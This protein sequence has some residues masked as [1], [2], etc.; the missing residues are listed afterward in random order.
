VKRFFS[1][2]GAGWVALLVALAIGAVLLAAQ[3]VR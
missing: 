3:V 1:E 2:L